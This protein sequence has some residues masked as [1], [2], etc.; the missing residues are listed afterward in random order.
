MIVIK[1]CR[2]RHEHVASDILFYSQ[3]F[4]RIN[5]NLREFAEIKIYN[6]VERT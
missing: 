2:K 6:I 5:N 3:T 1:E 4:N